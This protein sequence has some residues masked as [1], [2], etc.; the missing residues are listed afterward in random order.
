TACLNE[1][2]EEEIDMAQ[3]DGFIIPGKEHLECK[4]LKSLYGS[5]QAPRVWYQTLSALRMSRRFH[6]LI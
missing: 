1:F 2:L 3:L 5:K 4:L 6:K